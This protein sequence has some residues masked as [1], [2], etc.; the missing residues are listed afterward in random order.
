MRFLITVCL[1]G[2]IGLTAGRAGVVAPCSAGAAGENVI[3][4]SNGITTYCV[5]DFGW[6]DSWFLGAPLTNNPA[7]D[8][9][10]GDDAFNLKYTNFT[11]GGLGWLS[12]SLDQK[13]LTAQPVPSQY[14]VVTAVHSTGSGTAESIIANPDGLRITIDTSALG[15]GVFINLKITNTAAATIT[16]LALADYFNFHPNGAL[17]PANQA[18]TTSYLNGCIITT[19]APALPLLA[20]GIMCGSALPDNFDV[21]SLAFLDVQ[22]FTYNNF[23]GPLSGDIGGALEWNLGNLAPGASVS[24]SVAKN[25]PSPTLPAGGN[26]PE[27]STLLLALGALAFFAAARRRT[28]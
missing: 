22:N 13:T 10:S 20:N 12:P 16:G 6:S 18:G 27:P 15:P 21:S 7:R 24:F 23:A 26:V 3:P 8:M 4:V 11:R 28:R 2:S 5:S 19:V 14:T 25:N 9:L 1:F 17:A